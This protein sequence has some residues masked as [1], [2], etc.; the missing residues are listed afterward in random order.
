MASGFRVEPMEGLVIREEARHCSSGRAKLVRAD[1]PQAIGDHRRQRTN[2]VESSA[3]FA[4][5]RPRHGEYPRLAALQVSSSAWTAPSDFRDAVWR[6]VGLDRYDLTGDSDELY[7]A[8]N[9]V[10]RGWDRFGDAD[11][12]GVLTQYFGRRAV[13]WHLLS[14]LGE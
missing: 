2:R 12:V 3:R 11:L 14:T 6:V 10:E 4:R 5:V 1:F 8:M 13:R 9:W 7:E